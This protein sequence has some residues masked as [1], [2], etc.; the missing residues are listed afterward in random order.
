MVPNRE[1]LRMDGRL[2]AATLSPAIHQLL[3]T[4]AWLRNVV[5][6]LQIERERVDPESARWA[7]TDPPVRPGPKNLRRP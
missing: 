7:T 1:T 4:M 2:D 6:S 5:S 3:L